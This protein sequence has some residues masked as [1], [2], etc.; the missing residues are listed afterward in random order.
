MSRNRRI[1][2]IRTSNALNPVR[3]W[4][5]EVHRVP[6]ETHQGELSLLRPGA[7]SGRLLT[8]LMQVAVGADDVITDVTDDNITMNTCSDR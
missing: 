1:Q 3:T 8:H 5:Y 2:K 6:V 7:S 4:L